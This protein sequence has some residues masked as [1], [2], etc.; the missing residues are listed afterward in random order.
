MSTNE[1]VTEDGILPEIHLHS[2]YMNWF[3][4]CGVRFKAWGSAGP[5]FILT[6]LNLI[7]EVKNKDTNSNLKKAVKEI[8]ERK[9][10]IGKIDNYEAFFI[11]AGETIRYYNQTKE[12]HWQDVKL[13]KCIVFKEKDRDQFLD[14]IKQKGHKIKIDSHLEYALDF[15][16]NDKFKLNVTDAFQILFNLDKEIITT[17]RYLFINQATENE[18]E[19]HLVMDKVNREELLNFI[20][21]FTIDDVNKVKEY[22]KHN[23]SS[24]MPDDKKANLGKYYTPKEIVE[25]LRESIQ[26]RITFDTTVMDLS[27]GC[28]AFLELFDDCKIIGAD[29]DKTAIE[30]LDL[31]KFSNILHD[32]T[33]L[34]VSRDKYGLDKDDRVIIIGNPPYND[35]TSIN[36]RYSTKQK[37]ERLIQDEDIKCRDVGRSFL[38]AYAKL[39]PEY[40]C[41]LHPLSYL[42]KKNNL[43]DMKKLRA[44][45]RLAK[46]I[47]FSSHYFKDLTGGTPFPIIMATYEKNAEGMN[48]E[49]IKNFMFDIYGS[50]LKFSLSGVE[51]AGNDYIHQTVTSL[52][53]GFSDIDVYH[54]NFRDL[55]SIN[56]AN[57]QS[58]EYREKHKNSM[59]VVNFDNLWKYCYI[60]CIKKF[61]LPMLAEEHNYILGNLNPILDRR[62]I[63]S[64]LE[65]WS[66]L[67][68][69]G[70]ILKNTHRLDVFNI[71]NINR[72]FMS[73]K[74]VLNRFKHKVK[75]EESCGGKPNIY[76]MFLN[77]LDT[78]DSNIENEIYQVIR[79]YFKQLV[80]QCFFK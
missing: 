49:F 12:K 22:I 7:G 13:D 19:I 73:K 36:K 11:V 52:D 46:A 38:E 67:F 61:L 18:I 41:V 75:N 50:D 74:F 4:S 10:D 33:L 57:F 66:D 3:K 80:N 43:R 78:R 34:N 79:D 71:D 26:E 5:D 58:K 29:V 42:I 6:E 14:F 23:Y 51:Q 37:A 24:H 25:L 70:A 53:K 32:N 20:N 62:L 64:D 56:K 63:E 2:E 65:Y 54:Y 27:C 60:N 21:K 30:I 44:N 76:R 48:Y 69:M 55:N 8:Y 72:N 40:I 9:T 45:Y 35:S 28:G 59:L 16:L 39:E 15:I 47:I 1:V 31:F 77:Y 68:I 17:N